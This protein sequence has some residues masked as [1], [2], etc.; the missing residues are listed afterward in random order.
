M[1]RILVPETGAPGSVSASSTI[2]S[3]DT[4][5]EESETEDH[6]MMPQEFMD[7]GSEPI[8][9]ADLD[10]AWQAKYKFPVKAITIT[11]SHKNLV[12][13]DIILGS[14]RQHR[15]LI[16]ASDADAQEFAKDVQAQLDKEPVRIAQKL[17][18]T[19]K[20]VPLNDE[21]SITLLVE[22]CSARNLLAGDRYTSD[23][24]VQVLFDGKEIHRTDFIS[25]SLDPIWTVKTNSLFLWTVK[26]R[27]LF[28]SEGLHCFVFDYDQVGSH[29]NLGHVNI[30]PKI[31][32]DA[33]EERIEQPLKDP[34]NGA[35][36]A[37]FLAIRCRRASQYDQHFM[38][39]LAK[40]RKNEKLEGTLAELQKIK[41]L[42]SLATEMAGGSGNIPSM[43]KR[44]SKVVKSD[45]HPKGIKMVR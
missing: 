22:I 2:N 21:E 9:I 15:E 3:H 31:L 14:I 30:S 38:K 5:Q 35:D 28:I 44:R 43:L 41:N 20:G 13:V 26:T 34:H 37:G 23:P 27:D 4:G 18:A 17:D 25:R 24:Y 32:Y 10:G 7:D 11:R 12:S 40:T 8:A 1:V 45:Q 19:A 29:A 33:S 42:T 39:E 36:T 16:F 6:T